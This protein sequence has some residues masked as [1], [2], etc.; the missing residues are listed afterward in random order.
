MWRKR[1]QKSSHTPCHTWI[2]TEKKERERKKGKTRSKSCQTQHKSKRQMHWSCPFF[3]YLYIKLVLS[4]AGQSTGWAASLENKCQ[5]ISERRCSQ[6]GE[7]AEN[8]T[9]VGAV[10]ES[11]SVP[12]E[13]ILHLNPVPLWALHTLNF[14]IR[15]SNYYS[16]PGIRWL[17]LLTWHHFKCAWL[18]LGWDSG[19]E[20]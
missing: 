1:L 3:K 14:S 19:G 11:L 7:T 20:R 18:W 13:N 16:Q 17:Q 15:L 10:I 4:C 2:G 8:D 6:T 5:I 9:L 12:A